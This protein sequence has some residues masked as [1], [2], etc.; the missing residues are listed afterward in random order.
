[1]VHG[2]LIKVCGG[3][4]WSWLGWWWFWQD[5]ALS[6]VEQLYPCWAS[7]VFKGQILEVLHFA[8]ISPLANIV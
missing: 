7:S 8:K 3:V 5:L 4:G 1:M 6:Q 2:S